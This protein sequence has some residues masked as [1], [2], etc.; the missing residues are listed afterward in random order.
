MIHFVKRGRLFRPGHFSFRDNVDEHFPTVG[1]PF[2][3][4][5]I[6]LKIMVGI[7]IS[8]SLDFWFFRI[9]QH[10]K[11][12][13]QGRPAKTTKKYVLNHPAHLAMQP[14]K[15]SKTTQQALAARLGEGSSPP[16][17]SPQP[18]Q[19]PGVSAKVGKYVIRM[20][21]MQLHTG[22]GGVGGGHGDTHHRQKA[23][24]T[25]RDSGFGVQ[26]EAPE[27][28]V[29]SGVLHITPIYRVKYITSEPLSFR[30]SKRVNTPWW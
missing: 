19:N 7:Y 5:Y 21:W 11:K 3:Q 14:A 17:I 27:K 6:Q 20:P 22:H 24:R 4:M 15:T 18:S 23:K 1:F 29:L 28:W 8:S 10:E 12:S 26:G 2:F 16:K 25:K 30:C 9:L 13:P